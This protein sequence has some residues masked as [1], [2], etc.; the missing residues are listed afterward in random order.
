MMSLVLD[1]HGVF[2][3][4]R[5][6]SLYVKTPDGEKSRRSTYNLN[7]VVI[8]CR[9][10]IS[11][12]AIR[13]LA[14]NGIPVVYVSRG[15]PYALLHP[16]FNHGTVHTRREQLAAFRDS[17]GVHL[18][19]KFV[20]GAMVNKEKLLKYLARNREDTSPNEAARLSTI[21]GRIEE[22]VEDLD[23]EWDTLSTAR[24]RLMGIEARAA[25][26]YFKGL[27]M[28]IPDEF[29][30]EARERRP[31]K[32]PVNSMLSYGYAVLYSR[33]LIAIAACGLEPFAGFL[34]TDRSGKPSLVLDVVEEFRQVSVDR[35]I[36]RLITHQQVEPD[37]FHL[38]GGAV[39]MDDEVRRTLL[40]ELLEGMNGEVR[41]KGNKKRKL[42]RVIMRQCRQL[43]RFLI[44]KS[45]VYEPY[46]FRW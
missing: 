8:T 12:S 15:K 16:F 1:E 2:L 33:A 6:R 4:K 42:N 20:Q 32:D 17:R 19:Q 41:C 13:L 14:Q 7:E 21:A 45:N 44:G 10:T 31:A 24:N 23:R 26:Y 43:V 22:L 46:E 35:T 30:F 28:I 27:Q 5:G 25:K 11:S 36:I 9:C 38:E 37:S 34:H 3:G 39:M 29:N 40:R 18:A